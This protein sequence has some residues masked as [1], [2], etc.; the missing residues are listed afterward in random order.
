MRMDGILSFYLKLLTVVQLFQGV[1]AP[2]PRYNEPMEQMDLMEHE[3]DFCS[4]SN[5]CKPMSAF[6]CTCPTYTNFFVLN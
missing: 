4:I 1:P 5:D 3:R 2:V 6:I